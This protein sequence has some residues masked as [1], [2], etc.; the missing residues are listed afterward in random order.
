MAQK[1]LENSPAGVT[2][3]QTPLGAV[4]YENGVPSNEAVKP[5]DA[6]QIE[7]QRTE[8][9]DAGTAPNAEATELAKATKEAKKSEKV[10]DAG[11]ITNP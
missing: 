9:A 4:V 1:K 6:E 2:Q 8:N 10:K 11:P 7:T 5:K 3:E